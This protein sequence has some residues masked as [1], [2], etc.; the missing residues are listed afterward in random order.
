VGMFDA[1]YGC[2]LMHPDAAK[3][4]CKI[5]K[6]A[7][8]ICR[9]VQCSSETIHSRRD[10]AGAFPRPSRQGKGRRSAGATPEPAQQDSD[11]DD[12][13]VDDFSSGLLESLQKRNWAEVL[14]SPEN[15]LWVRL[16]SQGSLTLTVL[17]VGDALRLQGAG[18]RANP[19]PPPPTHTHA[20]KGVL[21]GELHSR[22][23]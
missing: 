22:T 7:G 17:E 4:I 14:L 5:V 15:C 3:Q 10:C 9:C 16:V 21:T 8:T 2:S 11:S 6:M 20:H 23:W 13:A 12:A 18:L 19:P 1:R